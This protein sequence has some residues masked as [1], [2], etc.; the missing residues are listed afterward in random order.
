MKA[1]PCASSTWLLIL[2][3]GCLPGVART[4]QVV[5]NAFTEQELRTLGNIT[6]YSP[7][8]TGFDNRYEGV[9]GTPYWYDNWQSGYVVVQG[10]GKLEKSIPLQLDAY[11]HMIYFR[12]EDK[13]AGFLPAKSVQSVILD[14]GSVWQSFPEAMVAGNKSEKWKFYRVLHQGDYLLLGSADKILKKADYQGAYSADRRYDEFLVEEG[15]FLSA[16]QK[17]FEK[18]KLKTKQIPKFFP[19]R[20]ATVERLIKKQGWDTET[21]TGF[22]QLLQALEKE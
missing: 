20:E 9:K 15:Y 17:S 2:V 19:G 14:D 18:I 21:E 12:I 11:N 16:D 8:V 3:M 6:P 10:K 13:V 22:V 1:A 4:Q 7:G 5:S